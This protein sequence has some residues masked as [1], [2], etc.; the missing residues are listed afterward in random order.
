MLKDLK[1]TIE[2][3]IMN[4]GESCTYLDMLDIYEPLEAYTNTILD[5]EGTSTLSRDN[6]IDNAM[7]E[8]ITDIIAEGHLLKAI[9]AFEEY[10]YRFNCEELAIEQAAIALSALRSGSLTPDTVS[11]LRKAADSIEFIYA[12]K[13]IE[14]QD[15]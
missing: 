4:E 6:T 11:K 8:F 7:C 15:L 5:T 9:E 13:D 2:Y 3:F 10:R 12:A 1:E 14:S